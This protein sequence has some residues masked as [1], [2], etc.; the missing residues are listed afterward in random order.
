M[1]RLYFLNLWLTCNKDTDYRT[2]K[3]VAAIVNNGK[4]KTIN[5]MVKT[6]KVLE[7]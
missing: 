1:T 5:G 4:N 6:L 2:F 3:T 7:V